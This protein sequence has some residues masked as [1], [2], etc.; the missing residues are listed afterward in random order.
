MK[1]RERNIQLKIWVTADE[2]K[3]IEHKTSLVPTNKISGIILIWQL[4]IA[5]CYVPYTAVN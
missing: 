4:L 1:N 2:R 5:V 3:L